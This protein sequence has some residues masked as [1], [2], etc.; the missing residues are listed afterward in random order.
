MSLSPNIPVESSETAFLGRF[1]A[2]VYAD[3]V[4]HTILTVSEIMAIE[5]TTFTNL[6]GPGWTGASGGFAGKTLKAGQSIKGW[7]TRIKLATGSVVAYK[8]A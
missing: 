1:G 8:G 2:V 3:T 7:F 5:D 4:D 6:E